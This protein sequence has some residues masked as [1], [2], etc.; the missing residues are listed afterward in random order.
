MKRNFAALGELG[1]ENIYF[2]ISEGINNNLTRIKGR[3]FINYSSYKYQAFF[4]DIAEFYKSLY[5]QFLTDPLLIRCE[6]V[7]ESNRRH[8]HCTILFLRET[9]NC[10][11]HR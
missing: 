8:F 10:A 2:K 9:A 6:T 7:Q 11:N 3:E 1:I 4:E 5:Y